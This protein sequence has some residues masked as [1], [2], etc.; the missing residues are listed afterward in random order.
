MLSSKNNIHS[1]FTLHTTLP[2]F[3]SADSSFFLTGGGDELLLLLL[4]LEPER[5]LTDGLLLES[6]HKCFLGGLRSELLL[7]ERE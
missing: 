4:L 3:D 7:L 2:Y 5:D 6:E 1:F